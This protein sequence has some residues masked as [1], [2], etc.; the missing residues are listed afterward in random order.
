MTSDETTPQRRIKRRYWLL[1]AVVVGVLV[2]PASLWLLRIPIAETAVRQVCNGRGINCELQID[3]LSF[4]SVSLHELEL[5]K[6]GAEPFTAERLEL[7]LDWNGWLSPILTSVNVSEPHLTIDTRGGEVKVD[8]LEALQSDESSGGSELELPPFAIE[9]G[10][11]TVLTD[12]GP[13]AGTLSSTGALQREVTSHISLE[14]A[15]L[16]MDGHDLDLRS[17]RADLVLAEGRV[18]G[19]VELDLRTAELETVSFADV[20]LEANITPASDHEYEASWQMRAER[21]A[22][23]DQAARGIR[24]D[25]VARLT[26]AGGEVSADNILLDAI[27]ATLT[28]DGFNV[29]NL[30][31]GQVAAQL[32]LSAEGDRLVGEIA[33]TS[34]LEL[35]DVMR[36]ERS[37]LTGNLSLD[38]S[39]LFNGE[40]TIE[41][42]ISIADAA[43]EPSFRQTLFASFTLPEPF[44]AHASKVQASLINLASGFSTGLDF[45]ASFRFLPFTYELSSIRPGNIQGDARNEILRIGSNGTEPWLNIDDENFAVQGNLQ[46]SS[47]STGIAL[48]ANRLALTMS[49]ANGTV[50]LSTRRLHLDNVEAAG[51]EIM[52]D[53]ARTDFQA[54]ASQRSL[55]ADGHI[56]FA[57]NAFGF[58]FDD[59]EVRARIQGFDAGNGWN[60][61][62]E[63][64]NCLGLNFETASLPTVAFGPAELE[65][66]A[67]NDLLFVQQGQAFSGGFLTDELDLPFR[68]GFAAGN[69]SL[70]NPQIIWRY[71]RQLDLEFGGDDL[72]I[73]MLLAIDEGGRRAHFR[74]E[75]ASTTLA[76]DDLGL[77]V[78]FDLTDNDASLENLPV[79]IDIAEIQGS[80]HAGAGGLNIDYS[81]LGALFTDAMNEPINAFYQ[82]L[83]MNGTGQLSAEGVA[84]DARLRLSERNAFIGD[85]SAIH[86]FSSNRGSAVLENGALTFE[87]GGLQLHHLS[88]RLRGLAVNAQG[89]LQPSAAFDWTDGVV[90][91]TGQVVVED[92]SFDTFRLGR[93]NGL[94]GTLNFDDLIGLRSAPAQ[95]LTLREFR[96]TPTLV[97]SD[98]VADISMLGPEGFALENAEWPFVGG[99][100]VIEPTV[101]NFDA[102]NQLVTIEAREW[103]LH[104]LLNLFALNDLDIAGRASGHFPIEIEG[105]NAYLRDAYLRS[106]EDGTLSYSGDVGNSAS[107]A[108]EYA[109]MAFDALRNFEYEILAVSANGN[110]VGNIVLGLQ[111]QGHNPDVLDGQ[112]FKLNISIDSELAELVHAGSMSASVQS[113]QD[114]ITDLIREERESQQND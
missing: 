45:N 113:T 75:F 52:I 2:I 43:L 87:A 94:S 103:D 26:F 10:R 38:R 5:T 76:T 77:N 30:N 55:S 48:S 23:P 79:D 84:L 114:M 27:D 85:L 62:F 98:G 28:L 46:F 21:L 72:M 60:F 74:S 3:Q 16:S 36:A 51:R 106:I 32:R 17:A 14:P 78:T 101:W 20:V 81:I 9:N 96:F 49:R 18:T 67:P 35:V 63:R 31:G 33:G 88:E 89:V 1:L 64:G 108:N 25:G 112:L 82:P 99:K 11:I 100:I 29:G 90:R 39:A 44:T 54:D 73:P 58:E 109:G 83:V 40:G 70:Q 53:F 68:T 57:G 105:A 42:V 41:G 34:E 37:V 69:L 61:R 111:M 95:R 19:Q 59:A 15:R 8:I 13:V 12:A 4:S 104:R 71:D 102:P 97:L 50:R 22:R 80:G 107:T 65:L 24:S 86:W 47:P 91:S 56:H 92:L 6:Q 110:L 93:L 66:C 7:S